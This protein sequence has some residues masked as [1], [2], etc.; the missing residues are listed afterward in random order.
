MTS[1]AKVPSPT[2]PGSGPPYVKNE[3]EDVRKH[4]LAAIS[5]MK[6]VAASGDAKI[7][8]DIMQGEQA[9]RRALI[10]VNK[11]LGLY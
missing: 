4:L 2:E 8:E 11:K 7:D 1:T 5:E 9:I 10:A 3:L 6:A